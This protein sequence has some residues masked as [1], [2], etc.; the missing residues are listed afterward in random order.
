MG[1]EFGFGGKKPV[2][3]GRGPIELRNA[4][5]KMHNAD[6]QLLEAKRKVPD[7]TGEWSA[8]DYYAEAEE[9][10]NR[11]VDNYYNTVMRLV[12]EELENAV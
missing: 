11:A 7:Y 4:L 6:L 12:R 2:P 5:V 10:Y 3:A 9:T 1:D 8:E